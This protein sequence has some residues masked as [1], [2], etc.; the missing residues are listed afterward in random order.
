[1]VAYTVA[2]MNTL[3]AYTDGASRDNPGLAS[4]GAV[5]FDGDVVL[6]EIRSFL[7]VQT[8]NWAEYEAVVQVLEKVS[9]LGLAHRSLEIR[10]DSKLVVEQLSGNW[11]IKKDTLREQ[12]NRIQAILKNGFTDVRYVHVPREKNEYADRLANEALD[13]R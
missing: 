2:Y 9:E 11:K 8:N 5:L 1:M 6:A 7:G 4:A 3:I 12:Y 10:M 13:N